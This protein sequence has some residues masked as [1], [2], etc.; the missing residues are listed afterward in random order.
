MPY[1][2]DVVQENL[3]AFKKETGIPG[4]IL[5]VTNE[6]AVENFSSVTSART[7][8]PMSL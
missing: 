6:A 8:L 5:D 1:V 4:A 2:V 7:A 3:D